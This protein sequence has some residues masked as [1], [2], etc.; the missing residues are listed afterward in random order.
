MVA[1]SNVVSVTGEE[2]HLF[3]NLGNSFSECIPLWFCGAP[4]KF[5]Y[6]VGMDG[7][8]C[9]PMPSNSQVRLIAGSSMQEADTFSVDHIKRSSC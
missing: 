2:P 8:I 9:N 6:D 5:L 1:G 4:K 3:D 7:L